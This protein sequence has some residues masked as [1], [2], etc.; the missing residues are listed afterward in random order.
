[1]ASVNKALSGRGG[2]WKHFV[3]AFHTFSQN[4]ATLV[5][6]HTLPPVCNTRRE[7]NICVCKY[8]ETHCKSNSILP[9][10]HNT[11]RNSLFRNYVKKCRT[12]DMCVREYVKT[13]RKV[14]TV[15]FAYVKTRREIDMNF[16]NVSKHVVQLKLFFVHMSKHIAKCS[17]CLLILQIIS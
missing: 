8:V 11:P 14:N 2:F 12:T 5:Q 10:W 6:V 16:A 15:V 17:S 7:I 9:M 13:P 3:Q 4:F 1:M